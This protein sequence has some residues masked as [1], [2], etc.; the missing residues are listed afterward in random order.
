MREASPP[1]RNMEVSVRRTIALRA[2]ALSLAMVGL[3]Y[4]LPAIGL[5]TADAPDSPDSNPNPDAVWLAHSHGVSKFRASDG[6]LLLDISDADDIRSL[7]ADPMR[8]TLW[9]YGHLLTAYG[10]SG[11]RLGAVRIERED[12]E[13]RRW[14]GRDRDDGHGRDDDDDDD[15]GRDDDGDDGGWHGI[16][17][18]VRLAASALDGGVWVA[19]DET[20][21]R[22]GPDGT[23]QWRV[24]LDDRAEALATDP[25][26]HRLW[27]AGR[28]ELTSYAVDGSQAGRIDLDAEALSY[29]PALDA[30]WAADKRRLYRLDP[31]GGV[32]FE[33]RLRR[34]EHL[35]ADHHGGV[36]VADRRT[37]R[38]LDGSG[39]VRF[40]LRPFP[41]SGGIEGLAVNPA[42]GSVWAI[43]PQSMVRVD[44]SGQATS[45][46]DFQ[47]RRYTGRVRDLATFGDVTPPEL[48]LTA[49]APGS[50]HTT[51][52]PEFRFE[53]ADGGSGIDPVTLALELDG[54]DVPLDCT[55]ADTGATCVPQTPLPEG[56]L[57]LG[58]TI[59]D[60]ADNRSEPVE[61][62]IT[63]DVT[64]PE[65]T[66]DPPD[67]GGYTNQTEATITGQVSEPA[68]LTVDDTTVALDVDN[69]FSHPVTLAEGTNT[70]VFT[71]VDPA[72]NS[73][74]ATIELVLDTISPDPVGAADLSVEFQDGTA[75]ITAPPG[76]AEP[77]ATVHVANERTGAT[78]SVQVDADGG[79]TAAIVAE[80][81]DTL[82]IQLADQA[83][84]TSNPTTLATGGEGPDPDDGF[85]PPAPAD[86]A[87][88]IDPTV[89]TD[90]FT[91]T[92]FLY[93]G[94][95]PIQR[96]VTEGTIERRRVAVLR[97]QVTD[98]AGDPI[99]GVRITILGHPEL[100][101]TGTRTDGMF[102]IAVNGGGNLVVQ[103]EKAGYLPVQ[104]RID[105]P[106]RDYAWLP[107][108]VMIPLDEQVTTI[109]LA[110]STT[111]QVARGSE[112]TDASGTRQATVL[113]PAGT[114]AEMVMPDGTTQPLTELNVRATEYTV[115]ENG[116]ESMPGALPPT[117]GYTYA[118]ELSVDQ[119]AAAGADQVRFSKQASVFVDNFLDFPVGLA[120]PAGW[121]NPADAA[122]H[123]S[124]NGRVIKIL[125]IVNDM[126]ELDITGDGQ[127]AAAGELNT[128]GITD[129]ER[130]Q[131]AQ[132][133]TEGD[134]LWWVPV[135]H[136][137][138]WDFNLG[139]GPPEDVRGP[140]QP[141]PEVDD[142][143]P[144]PCEKDGSIIECENQVLG[145][146]IPVAGTAQTLNYRS[147]RV[148]GRTVAY[149]MEISLSG[150][151]V[152][153]SLRRIDLR[154]GVA[155]RQIT[156]NFAAS[157]NQKFA[158]TWDGT[159]GFGR[160]LK[161]PQDVTV[162]VGYVYPAI[163][164]EPGSFPRSFGFPGIDSISGSAAREEVTLWQTWTKQ[165][166]P[167]GGGDSGS[168]RVE[169]VEPPFIWRDRGCPIPWG[170]GTAVWTALQCRYRFAFAESGFKERKS[171]CPD[172]C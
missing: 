124:E 146:Q 25:V 79:F 139:Y 12:R 10:P 112:V 27:V 119:A 96:G 21:V 86:V 5:T 17:A 75:V 154:I 74:E 160:H 123:P 134:V 137:S 105:T 126:V 52:T 147:D 98:R 2:C 78:V 40:E 51:Q 102:D 122:W 84:N 35:A 152:P 22:V 57:L 117:S 87:P 70:F 171:E 161:G 82:T 157:A 7:A 97:G 61:V 93:T 155:G 72:G 148:S 71:A 18:D 101:E 1:D 129:A 138:A 116:P 63:V 159:D 94:A 32:R 142:K 85:V 69:A 131:L 67:N 47:G 11:E 59:A 158:F 115:G 8:G 53:Y 24:E 168:G 100:G 164:Y 128:M 62:A 170:R 6:A 45:R 80:A 108:V 20:L 58:A 77:G 162:R 30:L 13:R 14:R 103:Y 64:P 37:L 136:F 141:E 151:Q 9:T 28:R 104:R 92:E 81:G 109:E 73:A 4:L 88:P 60:R 36:W 42:D 132:R 140:E 89:P 34:T 114:R 144:D 56:D 167:S 38:H 66:L 156:K 19:R 118:V 111:T 133:Y 68:E 127:A 95:N 49:P 39:L 41:R 130:V 165:L 149:S 121:Y 120:I 125:A 90:V 33:M 46:R 145:Q 110:D 135:D 55:H 31:D 65:I 91:A 172:W 169:S 26:R 15:R 150:N 23:E 3:A 44:L 143:E 107:D 106:W 113:F 48:F 54:T 16:D 153:D 50:L 29:A 99:P 83:G 163:Y 43:S 166:G 76:S